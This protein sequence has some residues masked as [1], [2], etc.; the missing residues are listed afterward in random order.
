MIQSHTAVGLRHHGLPAGEP[1]LKSVPWPHPTSQPGEGRQRKQRAPHALSLPKTPQDHH[2]ERKMPPRPVPTHQGS[3]SWV[4]IL[5]S[6]RLTGSVALRNSRE[7]V[8]FQSLFGRRGHRQPLPSPCPPTPAQGSHVSPRKAL[9]QPLSAKTA[10]VVNN[11][12][13]FNL[14]AL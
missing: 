8:T 9:S 4:Q 10:T 14:R 3:R 2:T 13:S 12:K 1:S 7:C 6:S 11:F 5:P